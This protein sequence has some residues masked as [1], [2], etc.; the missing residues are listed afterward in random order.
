M[1]FGFF[2]SWQLWEGGRWLELLESSIAKDI[3]TTE[4][5]RYINITL[6]CVQK[7]ADDGPTMSEIVA[8]INIESVI[9]R[10]PNHPT[11]FYLRVSRVHELV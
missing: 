4:A 1:Y 8:M 11:Y 3:N 2:Q 6:I 10:E 7:N 5:R 9:L